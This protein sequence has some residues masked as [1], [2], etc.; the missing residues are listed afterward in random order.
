MCVEV[1]AAVRVWVDVVGVGRWVWWCD[2]MCV[3][4]V[5]VYLYALRERERERV[6][7]WGGGGGGWEG[8]WGCVGVCVWVY[9]CVRQGLSPTHL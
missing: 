7:V 6:C 3:C 5:P 2:G 8:V 9:W 4:E 1:A